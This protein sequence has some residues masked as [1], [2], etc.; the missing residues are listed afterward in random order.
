[1]HKEYN[2]IWVVTLQGVLKTTLKTKEQVTIKHTAAFQCEIRV[3]F[4]FL[5]SGKHRLLKIL[6][7]SLTCII[8]LNKT[9]A[10]PFNLNE[11]VAVKPKRMYIDHKICK[12]NLLKWREKTSQHV[13]LLALFISYRTVS[14][15]R[16]WKSFDATG[17][18][19]VLGAVIP[20]CLFKFLLI[21]IV[22][23]MKLKKNIKVKSD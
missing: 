18:Q 9:M 1:M 4:L 17:S 11:T 5:S 3:L 20:M 15:W 12:D 6:T 22:K 19:W 8:V 14:T 10:D 16:F 21:M 23:T 13:N 7:V 2:L